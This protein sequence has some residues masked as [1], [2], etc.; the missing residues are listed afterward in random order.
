MARLR[1]PPIAQERVE[2]RP[3]GLVRIT[4]KKAY[5]DGTGRARLK[6]SLPLRPRPVVDR[7]PDRVDGQTHAQNEEHE[8]ESGCPIDVHSRKVD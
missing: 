7:P 1:A 3:D 2:Q 5:R 4:L 8:E 6:P